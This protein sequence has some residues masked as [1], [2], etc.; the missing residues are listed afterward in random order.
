LAELIR[1]RDTLRE[2]VAPIPGLES[3]L[4]HALAAQQSAVE[5]S[6]A[7]AE[8]LGALRDLQSQFS[9][10]TAALASIE[11]LVTAYRDWAQAAA[12]L[13]PLPA[14][15]TSEWMSTETR[16]T[17]LSLRDL[18]L[19]AQ[20]QATSSANRAAEA[21]ERE[22]LAVAERRATVG[23]RVREV[24]GR[25]ETVQEGFGIL[26]R[27]VADLEGRLAVLR[28]AA[29]QLVRVEAQI[30]ELAARRADDWDAVD[31]A[32][33][34]R[35]QQRR[36]VAAGLN[37][38]VG[39]VIKVE[40][41]PLADTSAYR[42]ALQSSLRGSGLHYA[43]LAP[44]LAASLMPR[45]LVDLAERDDVRGLASAAGL[46]T[47]RAEKLVRAIRQQGMPTLA[48]VSVDDVVHLSLLDGGM[49]K[50]TD[51]LSVGQRCTVVLPIILSRRGNILVLD[52]PEDHLDN[53][54][55]TTTL[56]RSLIAK[57]REDQVIVTT[58][59]PNIPVLGDADWVVV[60]GSDGRSSHVRHAGTLLEPRT[61]DAIVETMEGGRQAFDL[62]RR[63]YAG[64]HVH[65]G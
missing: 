60:L 26:A 65:G 49:Y 51:S 1:D 8:D 31:Q 29:D 61:V 38:S 39:P 35:T 53:A 52:Q 27:Q 58:H 48:T 6:S 36:A 5:E 10:L 30:R 23:D 21:L 50:D 47:E 37:A 43:E 11:D 7:T 20:R 4:A 13:G 16:Q 2:A 64:E 33:Q 14:D 54:F 55:I 34:E 41:S 63:Y 28:Q 17:I 3:E 62:R 40:V 12:S 57:K 19:D 25:V 15:G 59:N 56:V 32:W 42:E 9:V 46:A 18:A 22:R 45:E 24:R 44:K